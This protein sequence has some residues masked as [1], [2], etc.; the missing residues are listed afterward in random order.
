MDGEARGQVQSGVLGAMRVRL[1]Q[2]PSMGTLLSITPRR[3]SRDAGLY[4]DFRALSTQAD[5]RLALE[6]DDYD[7][8]PWSQSASGHRNL[9]EG[10]MDG[11]RLHN[12]VHV[13]VGGDM[14]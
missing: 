7:R 4:P 3:I 13:W 2:H 1:F 10:W 8:S 14:S 6:E 5:V 12:L 11:P 9:L